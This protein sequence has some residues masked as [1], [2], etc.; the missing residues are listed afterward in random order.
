[1]APYNHKMDRDISRLEITNVL[2]T[3]Y[4]ALRTPAVLAAGQ[5]AIQLRDV[6]KT[7]YTAAGEYRAL[8]SI[9]IEIYKG[10]FVSLVGKSGSGKST[11]LNMITGI[12]Y[13]TA[14]RVFV[15]QQDI[16]QMSESQR[17]L[18]RG[19]NIGIVF[20]FF[21]LLPMLT[22]LENTMLPMDYC[23]VYSPQERP[24]RA[25]ELM[26]MIGL[27]GEADKLPASV[28]SG[29]QQSAAIARALATN[30]PIIV[31]DEPTGN[32][33]SRSAEIIIE[34]FDQLTAQGK[35]ILIVTHDPSLTRRTD[36]TLV[37]SDGEIIDP[38][39]A[40][41]MPILNH[42]QMLA[43][44]RLLE[45][46]LYA[47][48][49]TIIRQGQQVDHFF[50]IVSGEVVV[51]LSRHNTPEMTVARLGAGQFFGE[52]ELMRGGASIAN[53]R[54]AQDGPVEL[55]LLPRQA[56]S[57][58]LAGSP[59][60]EEALAS[61]VQARLREN[62]GRDERRRHRPGDDRRPDWLKR[63]TRRSKSKKQKEKK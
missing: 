21:Q 12:D 24:Q 25:M 48:G 49:E 7:Y 13:P 5:I 50:L 26:Q 47:P 54:A 31:A 1:M 38:T 20:Q 29:Q 15:D 51:V 35:T 39:I 10:E 30:P 57:Q 56:F 32:L 61:V 9:D 11:L 27:E 42:N 46:R 36:R 4:Q 59:V 19:R 43:A 28:S 23:R 18:W 52:I 34:L 8:K 14:G 6:D 3:A 16:Y 53:V 22:L 58:L 41:A 37:I 63:A 44:T 45:R 62:R 40:Q 17:A 33:D 55:A 2:P 60:T